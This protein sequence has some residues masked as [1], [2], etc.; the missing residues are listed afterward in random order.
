MVKGWGE[1]G[2]GMGCS[3]TWGG[4]GGAWGRVG[5][6]IEGRERGVRDDLQSYPGPIHRAAWNCLWSLQTTCI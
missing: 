3:G 6:G 5:Q 2:G 1:S 4:L